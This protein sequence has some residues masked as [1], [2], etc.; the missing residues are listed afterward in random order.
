MSIHNGFKLR[1]T[2]HI[3]EAFCKCGE[4]LQE[5]NNGFLSTAMFCPKCE[6]V[7]ALKLVKVR[8]DKVPDRFIAQSYVNLPEYVWDKLPL[9]RLR[10]MLM[11]SAESPRHNLLR[12][13]IEDRAANKGE[14]E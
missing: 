11:M 1:A 8:T 10:K 5:V 3:H 4:E 14:K 7:Y 9:G 12:A 13:Y 6:S 2:P